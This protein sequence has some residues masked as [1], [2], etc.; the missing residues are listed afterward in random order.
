MLI[1]VLLLLFGP[2]DRIQPTERPTA[3]HLED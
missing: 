3:R 2:M 1:A